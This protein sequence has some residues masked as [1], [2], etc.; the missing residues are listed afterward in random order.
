MSIGFTAIVGDIAPGDGVSK[1]EKNKLETEA[2]D[3]IRNTLGHDTPA[4]LTNTR[5]F[6]CLQNRA[7]PMTD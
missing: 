6:A 5:K 7:C 2:M 3:E 4:G 1:E